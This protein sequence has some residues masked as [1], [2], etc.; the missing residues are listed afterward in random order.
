MYL[1]EV[2]ILGPGLGS[3]FVARQLL[4][5]SQHVFWVSSTCTQSGLISPSLDQCSLCSREAL[6]GSSDFT[7]WPY[8]YHMTDTTRCPS[9][10]LDCFCFLNQ[11]IVSS[12]SH[13]TILFPSCFSFRFRSGEMF[14]EHCDPKIEGTACNYGLLGRVQDSSPDE[15]CSLLRVM[16]EDGNLNK[17]AGRTS[18]WLWIEPQTPSHH[19]A[20]RLF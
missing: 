2:L 3:I 14:Q 6:G 20:H 11:T 10:W 1:G 13:L 18:T 8:I 4:M 17:S 5:H 12:S 19:R 16:Q 9:A 15:A 7:R